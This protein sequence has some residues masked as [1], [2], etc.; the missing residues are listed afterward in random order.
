MTED[1]SKSSYLLYIVVAFMMAG[2]I[3]TSFNQSNSDP[4][5]HPGAKD[6]TSSMIRLLLGDRIE[7]ARRSGV[8]VTDVM[9]Q[10][11]LYKVYNDLT[12]ATR[13]SEYAEN[14]RIIAGNAS[15]GSELKADK[16]TPKTTTDSD[17]QVV[18]T[19]AELAKIS[20]QSGF[21][22]DAFTTTN[23]NQDVY[24][25]SYA[26]IST[27]SQMITWA[28][29]TPKDSPTPN[30]TNAEIDQYYQTNISKRPDTYTFNL[31]EIKAGEGEKSTNQLID[32][33]RRSMLYA[34]DDLE[35]VAKHVN[36]PTRLFSSYRHEGS[37][38]RIPDSVFTSLSSL[39]V[40]EVSDPVVHNG[41]VYLVKLISITK[42]SKPEKSEVLDTIKQ[43]ISKLKSQRSKTNQLERLIKYTLASGWGLSDI[44]HELTAIRHVET[45]KVESSLPAFLRDR[46]GQMDPYVTGPGHAM[47][48]EHAGQVYIMFYN[49]PVY[50]K[51]QKMD[52]T[53]DPLR[54]SISETRLS[55]ELAYLLDSQ[56]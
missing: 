38:R 46:L 19:K 50:S 49:K 33:V 4:T 30:I 52:T 10:R 9:K 42:G 32:K 20:L 24:K 28:K 36:Q 15:I 26:I 55:G 11:L 53:L 40:D 34:P 8:E 56:Q 39:S 2:F 1:G 5:Q 41:S 22:R 6:K 44:S 18:K 43:S 48:V 25:R 17:M 23:H 54:H 21:I 3:Y 29:Y 37:Y 31:L 51:K 14:N 7:Y 16:Q 13:L 12:L 35:A 45:D 27:K 47:T